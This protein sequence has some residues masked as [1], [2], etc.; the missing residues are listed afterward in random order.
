MDHRIITR[1]DFLGAGLAV[2]GAALAGC[3]GPQHVGDGWDT[4]INGNSYAG[5]SQIGFSGWSVADGTV[6]GTGTTPAAPGYLISPQSYTD[7]ELRAEFWATHDCNSGIFIRCTD[8]NKIDAVN[9]YEV[10]IFDHRPDPSYG[11][12]AIVNVAKVDPMPKAGNRWNVYEITARGDHFFVVLNG[13]KTVDAHDGKNK[14]GPIA[15][16]NGGGTV[17]FKRVDIR[18]LA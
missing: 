11:T 13:Q 1:R 4:I 5:W 18:R 9:A 2:T 10:N 7:F 12:G 15:L 16:Q 8:R 3:A 17:R 14:A 6:Q